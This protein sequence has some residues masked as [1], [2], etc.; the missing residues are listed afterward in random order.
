MNRKMTQARRKMMMRIETLC[1]SRTADSASDPHQ[2]IRYLESLSEHTILRQASRTRLAAAHPQAGMTVLNLGCGT[3]S[4]ALMLAEAVGPSGQVH[5]VDRSRVMVEE[6]GR[7]ADAWGLKIVCE[8]ASAAALPYPDKMFDLV[9]VER[10]LLHVATPLDALIEIRRVLR[11]GRQLVVGETDCGG[12]MVTDA[13]DSDLA[14]RLEQRYSDGILHPSIGR[15][16]EGYA[17]SAR[18]SE[19]HVE[20][21]LF[22]VRDFDL[23]SSAARWPQM[24]ESLVSDGEISESRAQTW[25]H[26]A[27]VEARAGLAV[28]W[29]ARFDLFARR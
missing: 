3:G 4:D 6:T 13:G 25:L 21:G 28:C 10:V 1:E 24:L 23:A 7:R 26:T 27:A 19:I 18:F 29:V 14:R 20:P 2:L 22:A 9:W 8:E 16:L 15:A 11:D 5:A 12:L 17:R